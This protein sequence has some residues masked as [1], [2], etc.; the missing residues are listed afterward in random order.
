MADSSEMEPA[1]EMPAVFRKGRNLQLVGERQSQTSSTM[2]QRETALANK[3][4]ELQYVIATVKVALGTL[5]QRMMTLISLSGAVAMFAY[6]SLMPEGWRI[7]AACL[8]SILVF[9]PL[10][11]LDARGRE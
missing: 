5:S 11:W 9:G 8:Y 7:A 3:E 1:T 10:A 6:A 4:K 2:S